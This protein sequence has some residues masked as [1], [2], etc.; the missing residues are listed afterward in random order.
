MTDLLPPRI[1]HHAHLEG[2][3]D[4]LWVREQAQRAGKHIPEPLETLWRREIVPFEGFIEAFFFACGFIRGS[5]VASGISRFDEAGSG[6]GL[7][8]AEDKEVH[9]P[10]QLA[11]LAEA[12]LPRQRIFHTS[13]RRKQRNSPRLP[14][15]RGR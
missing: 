11:D 12:C 5:D 4:S 8:E 15:P 7:A 2:S 14:S 9:F 3:L 6:F 13:K 1:D 10:E